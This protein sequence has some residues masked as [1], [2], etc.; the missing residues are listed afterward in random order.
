MQSHGA[1]ITLAIYVDVLYYE[2]RI[3]IEWICFQCL[4]AHHSILG[5]PL[6]R[7][8]SELSIIQVSLLKSERNHYPDDSRQVPIP[9]SF[10]YYVSVCAIFFY[11]VARKS[12]TALFKLSVFVLYLY[13]SLISIGTYICISFLRH[14][15]HL[16]IN[17]C[18]MGKDLDEP[19]QVHLNILYQSKH[20]STNRVYHILYNLQG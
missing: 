15:S 8:R 4:D 18:R 19:V 20:L 14:L 7:T 12:P 6:P 5:S 2:L 9:A 10:W 13:L 1:V 11:T 16:Y 3:I 17:S